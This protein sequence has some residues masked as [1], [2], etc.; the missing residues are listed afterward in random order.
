MVDE[1]HTFDGAQGTDLACLIRRLKSRLNIPEGD[2]CCVGTS[3]TMGGESTAMALLGYAES[4]FGE[5][6]GEDAIVTED[7]LTGHEFL[8]NSEVDLY[9]V[10][11]DAEAEE[12]DLMAREED[13]EGY[14]EHAI[15]AWFE[16][17][18]R[19]AEPLTPDGRTE[20]ADKLMHH[21]FFQSLMGVMDGR[22]RKKLL[23]NCTEIS[24]QGILL[25]WF[26]HC[27]IRSPRCSSILP[28]AKRI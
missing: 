15:S 5:P 14:L 17:A 16:E 28:K 22:I 1:L 10:P 21:S 2:L 6:F 9:R 13:T 24:I 4:I 7:R 12:L 18:D 3:A 19:P 8:D 26:P 11:S 20:L 25:I 23:P 27:R